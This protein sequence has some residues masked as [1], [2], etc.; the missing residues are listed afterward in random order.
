MRLFGFPL[1]SE[2][3]SSHHSSCSDRNNGVSHPPNKMGK[4]LIKKL[5]SKQQK[6]AGTRESL[7]L[8]QTSEIASPPSGSANGASN[9]KNNNVAQNDLSEKK[10]IINSME[11]SKSSVKDSGNFESVK[12]TSIT[13]AVGANLNKVTVT[14]ADDIERLSVQ[15]ININ[16][17]E[18]PT[19]STA[20]VESKATTQKN[21]SSGRSH[22]LNNVRMSCGI[23]NHS[24]T[25]VV[26][27][28]TASSND[29]LR[30][31]AYNSIPLLDIVKLPRG[32]I[33]LHT[34]AVGRIQF[35][36]P[37]E[38]IKDSMRLG[39]SVPQVYIVPVERFCRE[40]G[41]ALGVNLA[42]FEFPAYFNFFINKKRCTL[43]VD[44]N[45]AERNIRRVFSETL[46]GPAQF[47]RTENPIEYEDEDF[48]P[49]FPKDQRPNFI[50]ELKY[51]RTNPDGSELTLET[52]LKFC[53]FEKPGE[54]GVH[55]NLA[56]PPV[57]QP[58]GK[59]NP[60]FS[61]P[62]QS[63][64]PEITSEI[65][66]D[67]DSDVEE[68]VE[69]K[70]PTEEEMAKYE[71]KK[72]K[73]WTYSYAKYAGEVA[74]VYP[75]N[76]TD[77]Q[78]ASKSCK[79][80]EVFK[81]PGGTEYIVHDIDENNFII[82]KARFS[83]NVRVSDTLSVIGYEGRGSIDSKG[84][85]SD[86]DSRTGL[87][88]K[89]SGL[90]HPLN[91]PVLPPTFHPPSF[92]VTVLGN[93]HGFDQSGSVS[94][95]VL[96]INGRGIMI[97]PP[98]YS[99]ATLEREG[100]RPRTIVG[101]ILTHCHAD[102]DAGAFQKVL[103]GSPVVV[104]TTPTIYKSF[105]RKYSALSA[106]SPALLRHSHRHKPAI[107]GA[108]LRFQGA[109]FRFTYTLHTIPCVG[110]RVEWRGRSIV[111]TGDHYNNPPAIDNL[112]ETGVLSK[113]RANDLR[114]L[115][116]QETDLILHEA[117]IPPIHTPFEVLMNLPTHIKKRLYVVHTS[118]LPENCDLNIAPVGTEGTLRLDTVNTQSPKP[119]MKSMRQ[120]MENE[121][122]EDDFRFQSM[123]NASEYGSSGV[124]SS[125]SRGLS[126]QTSISSS[127][128]PPLVSLRPTSST[129]AWYILNLLSAVPFLSSLSYASTM[130][131]LETAKVDAFCVNEIVVPANRRKE[132]LCV[133]WE[134]T[135]ME[136]EATATL[137]ETDSKNRNPN[138]RRTSTF[139]DY[140]GK[141]TPLDSKSKKKLGA[142]WHAGDW[143]GPRA[144]QPE[145][146]LSGESSSC[147]HFDIVA[148][149]QEGVKVI[150]VEFSNLHKILKS[151]SSL[152]R[153][154]LSR[155][156]NI[157]VADIP[158]CLQNAPSNHQ[159]Q[160]AVKK[161]SVIELL[162]CN[163]ALRKLSAVQKRHLESLAEGP[164]YFSA[165]KRLWQSQATVD[166]A[167]IVVAGTVSFVQKR[168]NAGSVGNARTSKDT[169]DLI[170]SMKMTVDDEYGGHSTQIS[171]GEAM[172]L[173]S[174]RVIQELNSRKGHLSS[175]SSISSTSSE[176]R[177][178]RQQH[179]STN[180][181]SQTTNGKEQNEEFF[182]LKN[183]L[184]Q[185]A[186]SFGGH[187]KQ[188]KRDSFS[189]QTSV[190]V[191]E[192]H[193]DTSHFSEASSNPKSQQKVGNEA[194]MM[195]KR[196]SRDRYANKVLGRLYSRRAFTAGLVFSRGHFLGDVSK[197]FAGQLASSYN[198]ETTQDDDHSGKYG[199]GDKIEGRDS[200]SAEAPIGELII[201]EKEGDQHIVH[202]STL[203]AGKNG[204][205]V[206]VFPDTSLIP[207][208]D[209]YP[210]LLLTL[211]GTQVVV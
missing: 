149:A 111:F 101:I 95:Y 68:V 69:M 103:I 100:I 10:A 27:K 63:D 133:V 210:G 74:T 208:L 191:E 113:A 37:P 89:G 193:D 8:K 72:R 5:F 87:N 11:K 65:K 158:P 56:I 71:E 19:D 78:I 170:T 96:W 109:T 178:S 142:V 23:P 206:L 166:K 128:E 121:S 9:S 204:C 92:G 16:N 138:E 86:K 165:G 150:T 36:I 143:T 131:V 135:C 108:P 167:F 73:S 151:G 7:T 39:L 81:L 115:P 203:A 118:N 173:D 137:D 199:F 124:E 175:N 54:S 32:G 98:P 144:L 35:G 85:T 52:L 168:R 45:D 196:S 24:K 25:K 125:V 120:I 83:G 146:R 82:G 58:D 90:N 145:K 189:T 66:E 99:S 177:D 75:A 148:M 20:T 198:N 122:W 112:E 77:D 184:Q 46:L 59:G 104:I 53:H 181:A 106:L 207:F 15:D 161:L 192:S 194:A 51:F 88:R 48:A 22:T 169:S 114:E 116:I 130:E 209:E 21:G 91:D 190:S 202:N 136:R 34:E 164:V 84:S 195:R 179:V 79:R 134:G 40:M 55:E 172:L 64:E 186:D 4:G 127:I 187:P 154:Y 126:R 13:P 67:D 197:M 80:V 119:S 156:A 171:V 183:G 123:W 50:K 139:Q 62:E 157:S 140:Q 129:D 180:V 200:N 14:V 12:E 2:R 70:V 41:A 176:E 185:R 182:R 105:I 43:L 38:T 49:N 201:Y 102:H 153:T 28:S 159:F 162:E 6:S 57:Y 160:D 44:S 29:P 1:K 117:G 26:I 107:I 155:R 17:D 152:Y 163:S 3:K 94:G 76:A 31:A 93:S 147:T 211:L 174:M 132:V 33:S 188:A 61:N 30:N 205:V 47:R 18:H 42:E 110:F 60:S 97:D 141:H